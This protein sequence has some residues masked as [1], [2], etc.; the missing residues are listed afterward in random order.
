MEEE[1]YEQ[2]RLFGAN[3][4][5]GLDCNIKAATE[6]LA[7]LNEALA[8]NPGLIPFLTKKNNQ[9]VFGEISEMLNKKGKKDIFSTITAVQKIAKKLEM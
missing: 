2:L 7:S 6:G 8:K 1:Y 4:L 3:V 5:G 9:E